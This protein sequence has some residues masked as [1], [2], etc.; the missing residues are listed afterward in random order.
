MLRQ[1]A[2]CLSVATIVWSPCH[3]AGPDRAASARAAAPIDVTGY[4]VAAINEDWRWR[5]LTPAK[6]DYGNVPLNN[7]GRRLADSWD[8]QR[9]LANGDGC[10]A[11]GVGGVMRMPTH[12]R[13]SWAD[14]NTLRIDTDMGQQTRLVHFDPDEADGAGTLQGKSVGNWE[15]NSLHIETTDM[16]PGYLRRNGIP[17]GDKTVINEWVD[18]HSTFGVDWL[19]ITSEVVDPEYL[20]RKFVTNAS[21]KRSKK[22]DWSPAACGAGGGAVI[23]GNRIVR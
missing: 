3:A 5:V 21:F 14:E 17:Y 4:W 10:K 19:T 15:D 13:I 11:Y 9:D 22:A 2:L 7:R 23:E 6:G 18:Q 20:S 12:L 16:A 8:P 1:T